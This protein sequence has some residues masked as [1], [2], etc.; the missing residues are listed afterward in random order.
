MSFLFA[1]DFRVAI[2]LIDVYTNIYIIC[3]KS[4]SILS[5]WGNVWHISWY[6]FFSFLD[7]KAYYFIKVIDSIHWNLKCLVWCICFVSFRILS[8]LLNWA[9]EN[10]NWVKE[11]LFHVSL[12]I[13]WWEICLKIF[14]LC[15]NVIFLWKSFGKYSL[16]YSHLGVYIYF[17]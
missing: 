3:I 14:S 8:F 16:E 9:L 7:E 1:F 17:K 6:F 15:C 13:I 12:C 2:A 11:N 10:V 5:I 4:E